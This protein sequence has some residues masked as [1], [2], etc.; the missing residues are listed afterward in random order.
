MEQETLPQEKDG[1]M[2]TSIRRKMFF[3][4]VLLVITVAAAALMPALYFFSD[5]LEQEQERAAMQGVSGLE[6]IME[7]YKAEAVHYATVFSKYSALVKALEDK[8][9]AALLRLAGQMR[10]DSGVDF[11]TITDERGIVIIRS[12]EPLRQ[13]DSLA[14]AADV[15]AALAGRTQAAIEPGTVIRLAIRA[16][17]PVKNERGQIVGVVSLGYDASRDEI[18]DRAK[19]LF[20]TEATLFLGDERVSTTIVKDGRRVV[21]TKLNETVAATVLGE[22]KRYLG[23]AEILGTEY[24]TAYLPVVGPD[25][26]PIGAFFAGESLANFLAAR[27]KIIMIVGFIILCLLIGAI[28]LT[29][30][31][32][33][34]N[35]EA[36]KTALEQTVLFRTEELRESEAR[37]RAVVEAQTDCIY[38]CTPD[39]KLIFVNDAFCRFYNVQRKAVLGNSMALLLG[40]QE[41]KLVNEQ[42]GLLT[43]GNPLATSQMPY[44][45]PDGSVR[46]IEYVCQAFFDGMGN[47]IEYQAVGRDITAQKEAE[48]AIVK[49]RETIHRASRVMTLAVIG[50]G[51]A[52][53]IKQPLNAIKIL[54]ET[55][56][57]LQQR[58]GDCSDSQIIQSVHSISQ[59]VDKIDA[60]VNHLRSLPRS[61]QSFEYVPCDLNT[62]VEK[63][64]SVVSHQLA[65]KQICLQKTLAPELPPVYGILVRFE[66]V[67]FNLLL[68]AIQALDSITEKQKEIHVRTWVDAAIH[69]E[70]SDNG[71]GIDP[72]IRDR[73]LEPFFTTKKNAESMGL[74]MAIVQSAVAA[75]HGVLKV[76]N[77]SAGGAN[78]QV[79]FP[80]GCPEQ[81]DAEAAVGKRPPQ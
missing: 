65:A 60:I 43:P 69:L 71:P 52:H 62:A 67:V 37:Y 61:S 72:E 66:E 30:N 57:Y 4:V 22:G 7:E 79:S 14:A 54:V 25:D 45:R 75:S 78:I 36:A 13:G 31:R 74:G 48:A 49:A 5:M 38:H 68:N 73:I 27:N 24:M 15:Q 64:V 63:A 3:G 10:E 11:V 33:E 59:Q 40:N 2:A 70:I 76:R 80:L 6:N 47:V 50:G 58:A 9:A 18:V 42:E 19:Q 55:I 77:N 16:G 34:R 8:D 17:A 39:G 53:E 35:L 32:L 51:I 12:H 41:R 56:S 21:G 1:K 20:H 81:A 29:A 44:V 23:R 26:K 28:F 46:W